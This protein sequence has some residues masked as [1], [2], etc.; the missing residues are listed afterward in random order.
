[1]TLKIYSWSEN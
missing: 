1:M